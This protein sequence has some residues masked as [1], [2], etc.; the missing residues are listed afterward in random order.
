VSATAGG[1]V[2]NGDSDLK[3]RLS[4][5]YVEVEAQWTGLTPGC[6]SSTNAVDDHSAATV[7]ASLGHTPE[8]LSHVRSFDELRAVAA[9]VGLDD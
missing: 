2:R 8:L 9:L 5:R 1:P 3:Y 4:D 6:S 7:V